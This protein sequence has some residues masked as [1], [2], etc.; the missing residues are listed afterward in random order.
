M[1]WG[2]KFL[3]PVFTSAGQIGVYPAEPGAA[4]GRDVAFARLVGCLA[5]VRD[6]ARAR[7]REDIGLEEFGVIGDY[8]RPPQDG[9]KA[10]KL[11][12]PRDTQQGPV[13]D[14]QLRCDE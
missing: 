12:E 13:Q 9:Y 3:L 14:R 2:T 10:V 8:V 4:A 7:L 11:H 1:G 6:R 5:R